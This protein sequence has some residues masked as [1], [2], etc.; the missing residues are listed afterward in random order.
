MFASNATLLLRRI[1]AFDA[2]VSLATGVLCLAG[3][4]VL[5]QW[6]ALPVPV[7]RLSGVFLIVCAGFIGWL[8][9]RQQPPRALVWIVIAGNAL[10]AIESVVSLWSG[11]LQPNTLGAAFVIVQ[12][13]TVAGIAELEYI[14]LSR[15]PV[16]V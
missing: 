8:A 3:A 1:L 9:S 16:T 11:W 4:D 14:A 2:T 10:W 15:Q 7:L 6:L 13:L 5:H 12:A